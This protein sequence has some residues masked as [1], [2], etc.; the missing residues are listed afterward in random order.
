VDKGSVKVKRRYR[1]AIDPSQICVIEIGS[2]CDVRPNLCGYGRLI[3]D[4]EWLQKFSA[5]K[6]LPDSAT[7]IALH[8]FHSTDRLMLFAA[9]AF[10]EVFVTINS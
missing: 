6:S 4:V 7:T 2:K 8:S 1:K 3:L 5:D 10:L 9:Q